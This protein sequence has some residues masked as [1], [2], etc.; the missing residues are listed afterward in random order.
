MEFS[1]FSGFIIKKNAGFVKT[2]PA[3]L[4]LNQ[5]SV[6]LNRNLIKRYADWLYG[7][8]FA[9]IRLRADCISTAAG[10]PGSLR[11]IISI[12]PMSWKEADPAVCL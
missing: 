8:H 6:L 1:V 5:V 11:D 10:W 7:N 4:R 9:K 12:F 3:F 2:P